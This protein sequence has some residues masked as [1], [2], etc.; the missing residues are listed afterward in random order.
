MQINN[1]AKCSCFFF[2]QDALV[3][4]SRSF[5]YERGE[6]REKE[7]HKEAEFT[8]GLLMLFFD[9]TRVLLPAC[10]VLIRLTRLVSPCVRWS[11]SSSSRRSS[12]V[13]ISIYIHYVSSATSLQ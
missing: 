7:R 6:K 1:K 10:L 12:R 11:S 2:C 3:E 9:N 13:V 5:R 8:G 4:S